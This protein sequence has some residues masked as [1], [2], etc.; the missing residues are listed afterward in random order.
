MLDFHKK[1]GKEGTILVTKVE[2][3]SK[4]GVIVSDENGKIE[5][6]V[7]KPKVFVGNK[8]NAGIYI[9]NTSM[10]SR[11]QLRPTSIETE[12]FPSMAADSQLYCFCLQQF[13]MDIGQPKDYLKG[14]S[15][16]LEFAQDIL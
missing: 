7:E 14:L 16:Y 6:F 5:R 4:Y 3:P 9:L 12:V 2:E 1:H 11:I 8:I 10:L 13:W 15:L